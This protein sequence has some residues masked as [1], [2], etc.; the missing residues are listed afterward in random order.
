[1]TLS[2]VHEVEVGG[3]TI[4]HKL[5]TALRSSGTDISLAYGH[6]D[7]L[8]LLFHQGFPS[9]GIMENKIWGR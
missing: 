6:M 4:W 7:N 8:G 3:D 9:A 1:M 5:Q 2:W